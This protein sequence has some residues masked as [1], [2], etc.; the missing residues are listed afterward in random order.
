MRGQSLPWQPW[1]IDTASNLR[2]VLLGGVRKRSVELKALNQRLIETDR[3]KDA[4]IATVSH[5]LRTPLNAISG[6]AQLMQSGKLAPDRQA[7]AL[8]VIARNANAQSQI[9]EDLLDVSRMTSG[10]MTLDIESVD[11]PKLIEA[12]IESQ[13][14]ALGAKDIKCKSILDSHASPVLGDAARLRQVTT[15]LITN[16]IK[17]TPKGGT[18]T[19]TL[20]RVST[21][22]EFSVKDTG[23]G[24]DAEFLP[25]IF[26]PFRQEDPGMNRRSQGLGLGLAIVRKLVELH[27]GRVS[28]ESGGMGTGALFVVHLPVAPP[29]EQPNVV[30]MPEMS[31]VPLP[32]ELEGVRL[33]VVEDELDSRE[34]LVEVLTQ[35]GA[36]VSQAANADDALALAERETF[37][38]IVSDIGLPGTDGMQLLRSIRKRPGKQIPAIALTAYT[39]AVDRTRTLQ[40]GFSAHVP[41]PVDKEELLTVIA[42]LVGRLTNE[43]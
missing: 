16:A 14:L 43:A 18:I 24:I 3:A 10:K 29:R 39:R 28:A 40:A 23:I 37:D 25:H 27:G 5:E 19:V 38:I 11:L 34:F 8:E 31:A 1:Q 12:V 4:F 13:T 41:K 2:R 30:E 6:W 32:T 20:R 35:G 36:I 17:F 15:N 21:D 42:S 33:L 22:I 7:H 9:V 26:E